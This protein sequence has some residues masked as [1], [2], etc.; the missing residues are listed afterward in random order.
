MIIETI[1]ILALI[2]I[3]TSKETSSALLSIGS[4]YGVLFIVLALFL[5]INSV[6]LSRHLAIWG[7]S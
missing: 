6:A 5:L 7:E 4:G 3:L 1:I 2:G